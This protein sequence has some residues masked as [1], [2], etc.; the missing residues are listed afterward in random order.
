MRRVLDYCKRHVAETLL[1]AENVENFGIEND[2]TLF[3]CGD[4]YGYFD[5]HDYLTGIAFFGNFGNSLIHFEERS[6]ALEFAKVAERYNV[7]S[8]EGTERMIQPIYNGYCKNNDCSFINQA[9]YCV[10]QETKNS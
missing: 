6:V 7:K 5:E 3:N 4:Y 1:I 10:V 8:L 9:Q 2:K